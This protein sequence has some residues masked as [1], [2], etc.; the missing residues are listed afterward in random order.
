MNTIMMHKKNRAVQSMGGIY[1]LGG[2]C[3]GGKCPG[4]KCLGPG[5]CMSLMY[6]IVYD[7]AN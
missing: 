5:G 7:K 3:P 6:V 4:S 2:I 1:V